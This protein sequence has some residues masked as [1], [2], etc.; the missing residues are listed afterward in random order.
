MGDMGSMNQKNEDFSKLIQGNKVFRGKNR[1]FRELSEEQ[2][3]EFVIISCSDSRVSP[4][5]VMDAPL[6]S[7]FEIRVA[8]EV[9]DDYTLG[10][11][12]FAVDKLGTRKIMVMGH[13]KCGAVTAAY[14]T[15]KNGGKQSDD[16]SHL[17]LL[18][19][20]ICDI[21]SKIPEKNFSLENCISENT[22]TQAS[23]LLSSPIIKE[24]YEGDGLKIVT[25][26][27]DLESGVLEISSTSGF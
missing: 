4:S 5:L 22:R 15:L 25:A 8:G 20:D 19:K 1:E 10:S 23:R 27:Y 7:I 11:V 2:N 24:H 14:E 17:S 3:P 16:T 26:L 6:G 18:V 12:E 9:M 21:I 13:T